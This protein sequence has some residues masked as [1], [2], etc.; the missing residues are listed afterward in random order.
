MKKARKEYYPQYIT[1]HTVREV[2]DIVLPT[3]GLISDLLDEDPALSHLTP[4]EAELFITWLNIYDKYVLLV[5]RAQET[6]RLI[7]FK[8]DLFHLL[9]MVTSFR[10]IPSY[11]M[12]GVYDG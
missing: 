6:G 7:P 11:V 8:A 1:A 5:A 9:E 12:D 3:I 2:L 10:E 4:L